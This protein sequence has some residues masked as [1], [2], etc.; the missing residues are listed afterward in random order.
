MATLSQFSFH[1]RTIKGSMIGASQAQP[2]GTD[3]YLYYDVVQDVINAAPATV[4][5]ISA[6]LNAYQP[7]SGDGKRVGVVAYD[8]VNARW[9]FINTVDIALVNNG[10]LND[11]GAIKDFC[12]GLPTPQTLEQVSADQLTYPA[13]MAPVTAG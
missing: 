13:A 3:G 5:N 1:P 6:N 8:Y 12:A 10:W 9:S 4:T 2:T 7:G 11:A